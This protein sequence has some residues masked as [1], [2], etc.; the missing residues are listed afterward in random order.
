MAIV[1]TILF[2]IP[3]FSKGQDYKII[4][5]DGVTWFAFT[6]QR[7]ALIADTLTDMRYKRALRIQLIDSL[8]EALS[9]FGALQQSLELQIST[10]EAVGENQ[11]RQLE[12]K[13]TSINALM[14]ERK[15]A[16]AATEALQKALSAQ[17]KRQRYIIGGAAAILVTSL[18]IALR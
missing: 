4:E 18:I 9:S 13:Q 11:S 8:S 17:K 10:L 1:L 5:Q 14:E 6:R 3:L 7:A 15:D 12:L 2:L 16:Y